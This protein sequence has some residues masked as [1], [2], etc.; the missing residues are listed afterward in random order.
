M[1][2]KDTVK[3]YNEYLSER[4]R[5]PREDAYNEMMTTLLKN[6]TH[7]GFYTN[8]CD[9]SIDNVYFKNKK[10]ELECSTNS[11]S[12]VSIS[13]DYEMIDGDVNR[14]GIVWDSIV[15]GI[16]SAEKAIEDNKKRLRENNKIKEAHE[17]CGTDCPIEVN[18][19]LLMIPAYISNMRT[20]VKELET[21]KIKLIYED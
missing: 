14:L 7:C 21:K 5:D 12:Y 20:K 11:C 18:N 9:F 1:S 15:Y 19:N 8:W 10:L 13:I 2:V 17:I 3:A 6:V 16:S 4:K